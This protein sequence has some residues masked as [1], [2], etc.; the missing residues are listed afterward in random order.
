MSELFCQFLEEF[1]FKQISVLSRDAEKA[2]HVL[3]PLCSENSL[4]NAA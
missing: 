3:S 2:A 1:L 4:S